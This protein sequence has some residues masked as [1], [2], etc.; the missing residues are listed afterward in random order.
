MRLASLSRTRRFR[1]TKLGIDFPVVAYDPPFVLTLPSFIKPFL[2]RV[3]DAILD[4]VDGK[5]IFDK[6]IH[7]KTLLELSRYIHFQ[8]VI[9]FQV[10][11]GIFFY[12]LRKALGLNLYFNIS[13][14]QYSRGVGRLMYYFFPG[15]VSCILYDEHIPLSFMAF[16]VDGKTLATSFRDF[17]FA[18]KATGRLNLSGISVLAWTSNYFLGYPTRI[19]LDSTDSK[20]PS[21]KDLLITTAASIPGYNPQIAIKSFYREA[22]KRQYAE[23]SFPGNSQAINFSSMSDS[24]IT[25][26]I[27]VF[28]RRGKYRFEI[29]G[30]RKALSC[31][32][33]K[34]V[35]NIIFPIALL[36]ENNHKSSE[37]QST[38]QKN[39]SGFILGYKMGKP[40][41]V[42]M[43]STSFVRLRVNELLP[44]IKKVCSDTGIKFFAYVH[45]DDGGAVG[46]FYFDGKK[47]QR[48]S[49]IWGHCF[50]SMVGFV[51]TAKVQKSLSALK[52]NY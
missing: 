34:N 19:Q 37:W 39:V 46:D 49:P 32:G 11:V 5:V 7:K 44:F 23:E 8:V 28:K 15:L 20:K 1:V 16:Q 10:V 17:D 14:K 51:N 26:P 13:K 45:T 38:P 4:S 43:G 21:L 31:M 30:Q 12:K 41:S 22:F 42:S 27:T 29:I 48:F 25:R 36:T 18:K 40:V 6:K 35:V 50:S 33:K 47:V 2:R 52:K 3:T 24:E 9:L